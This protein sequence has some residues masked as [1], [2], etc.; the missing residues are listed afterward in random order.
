MNEWSGWLREFTDP[1]TGY[2]FRYFFYKPGTTLLQYLIDGDL[3]GVDIL[4][5]GTFQ[6]LEYSWEY[7]ENT[8]SFGMPK[9]PSMKIKFNLNVTS[10]TSNPTFNNFNKQL[11]YPFITI[12]E[13]YDIDGHLPIP[14]SISIET[15]TVLRV[16]IKL[17]GTW[18]EVFA[19]IQITGLS[20]GLDIKK[21]T[22]E[23][24][25]IDIGYSVATR[26]DM[27]WLKYYC[28]LDYASLS[29][30]PNYYDWL[31]YITEPGG[32]KRYEANIMF[33]KVTSGIYTERKDIGFF[34]MRLYS[35]LY[36][37]LEVLSS[38]IATLILREDV[39]ISITPPAITYYKQLYNA[40]GH[41]GASLDYNHIFIPAYVSAIDM[42][43]IATSIITDSKLSFLQG[44]CFI[45]LQADFATLWDFLS[46]LFKEGINRY[47]FNIQT[48]TFESNKWYQTDSFSLDYLSEDITTKIDSPEFNPGTD[49]VKRCQ[50]ATIE[51]VGEDINLFEVVN[52]SS[53]AEKTINIP[54]IFNNIPCATDSH[55][56]I[57]FNKTE[58]QGII[59]VTTNFLWS[60]EPKNQLRMKQEGHL[61]QLLY[62]DS[63]PTDGSA[64]MIVTPHTSS[65]STGAFIRVHEY[66]L[67]DFGDSNTSITVTSKNTL[68]TEIPYMD[69]LSLIG[70]SR[71]N[72]PI[73]VNESKYCQ[74]ESGKQR[75]IA[76]SLL[77]MFGSAKSSTINITS[78]FL[79]CINTNFWWF[80]PKEKIN[81]DITNLT[82]SNDITLL[83]D[84]DY[85]TEYYPVKCKVDLIKMVCETSLIGI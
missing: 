14:I 34:W 27:K 49:I 15:S 47:W 44:G 60:H 48:M 58:T 76:W 63:S 66:C 26:V 62:Y 54:V 72:H 20:K 68:G 57:D 40:S 55:G 16:Y 36:T 17:S 81:I 11:I 7:D 65:N 73:D 82:P 83:D 78:S 46:D 74:M 38:H 77:G 79:S 22:F 53:R 33:T 64:I 2:E 35:N 1:I 39:S 8:P 31:Y 30:A 29:N 6:T 18:K 3:T 85:P 24:D 52:P 21:G 4:P 10:I 37:Y 42:N 12:A 5:E 13:S 84:I 59:E 32:G 41:L 19:G 69:W 75:I 51:K 80:Y 9:A 23:T 50:V 25:F 28:L 70:T 56:K 61:R 45:D 67:I 71:D 43:D